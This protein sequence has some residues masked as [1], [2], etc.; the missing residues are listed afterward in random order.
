LQEDT[1]RAIAMSLR[2]GGMLQ[3]ASDIPDYISWV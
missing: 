3:V 1:L 2:P